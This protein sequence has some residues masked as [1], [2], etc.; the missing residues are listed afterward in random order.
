MVESDCL[1]LI[2]KLNQ[3]CI[4][5]G[6]IGFIIREI[7]SISA[8]MTSVAWRFTRRKANNAAHY[9][10]SLKPLQMCFFSSARLIPQTFADTLL[11]DF[12]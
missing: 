1:P 6:E 2:N 7:R 10:A 8:R 5:R 12:I 3:V 9:L 4:H 11:A